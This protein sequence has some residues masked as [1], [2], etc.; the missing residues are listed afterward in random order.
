M[1]FWFKKKEVVLDCFTYYS[2][3]YEVFK[4][5]K[6]VKFIPPWFKNLKELEKG[7]F[8]DPFK[9]PVITMRKCSGF[10]NYF[11]ESIAMPM[12]EYAHVRVTHEGYDTFKKVTEIATHSKQQYQGFLNDTFLHIK[13]DTPWLF[14][15]N[16]KVKFIQTLPT[17]CLEP[18][19]NPG[20]F[21]HMPGIVDFHYQMNTNVNGFFKKPE[22]PEGSY[23]TT[24][25]PGVPLIFY[26]P[27]EDV[28]VKIKHH[29]LSKTDY[30][31]M[32]TF[33]HDSPG[34]NRLAIHKKFVDKRDN[35]VKCPFGF[36]KNK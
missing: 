17:W 27:T 24:F 9:T 28:K 34:P 31:Q 13:I 10:L 8:T 36:G 14:K 16:S 25:E 1:L 32:N 2:A 23:I 4:I 35:E 7:N 33:V 21:L 6:A 30:A 18:K 15:A 29:L 5:D 11:S 3:A 22:T 19:H 26:T 20:S 12:W